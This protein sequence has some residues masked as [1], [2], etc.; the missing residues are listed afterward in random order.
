LSF[1]RETGR[2]AAM[3]K[4]SLKARRTAARLAAVQALYALEVGEGSSNGVVRDVGLLRQHDIPEALIEPDAELLRSIVSGVPE[5]LDDVDSL[6]SGAMEG[7]AFAHT[8]AVLRAIL[9]AG[10]FELLHEAE[11]PAGIIINDYMNIAH[12]YFSSG[13]PAKVNAV[14][15][16]VTKQLQ[17][18]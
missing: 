16:K 6:V 7:R 15:D 2:E 5:R 13:E 3:S 10:V 14:L 1:T 11:T 18:I 17:R 4:S 8:E 12:A 9:R